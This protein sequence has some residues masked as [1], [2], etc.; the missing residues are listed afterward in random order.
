MT[1][2]SLRSARLDLIYVS[3]AKA[4]NP[5]GTG[6]SGAFQLGWNGKPVGAISLVGSTPTQA[7]I[8][9]GIEPEFRNLG[10]ASEAVAAVMRATPRFGLSMLTAQCRS[11]NAASR[12]LLEKVGF[13]LASSSPWQANGGDSSLQYMVYIWVAAPL[14][15]DAL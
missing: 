4:S 14:D 8:G 2:G 3:N 11:D 10:L 6:R 1:P 7:N 12:R 9:F 13:E 15:R 5:D